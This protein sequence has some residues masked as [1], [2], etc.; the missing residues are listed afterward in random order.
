[1]LVEA[2]RH[3]AGTVLAIEQLDRLLELLSEHGP[4]GLWSVDRYALQLVIEAPTPE[5]AL[6]T[7][8]GRWREAAGKAGLPEWQLV[9]AELKTPAELEAEHRAGAEDDG[10]TE[11]VAT[12]EVALRAAYVATRRLL[13]CG[14]RAE[15]AGIVSDLAR[16]LGAT[17][18]GSGDDISALPLDLSLGEARARFA[19][20]DPISMARLELEEVLP[21]V[22]LDAAQAIRLVEPGLLVES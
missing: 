10:S 13:Y 21:T 2:E 14:S 16:R 18:V 5:A 7:G 8:L 22:M 12:S 3:T 20:A 1:V 15:A 4:S 17:L 19:V 11:S 9:R 6:I